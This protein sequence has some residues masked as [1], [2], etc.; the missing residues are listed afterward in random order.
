MDLGNERVP[1][2]LLFRLHDVVYKN[3]II[4][5]YREEDQDLER[6]LDI[7]VRTNSGGTALSYSDML[8][9]TATAQWE[10]LDAREEIQRA[11]HEINQVGNG[12]R[13]SQ[14]FVPEGEPDAG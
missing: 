3:P 9:S 7:F 1:S 13:F 10:N 12:F 6:V 4:A 11:V 2:R 5:Y 8:M 14:D